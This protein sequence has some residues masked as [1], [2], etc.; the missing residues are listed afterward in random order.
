MRDLHVKDAS[1]DL[2]PLDTIVLL[3]IRACLSTVVCDDCGPDETTM[4]SQASRSVQRRSCLEGLIKNSGLADL[5]VS[6]RCSRF[7]ASS[8]AQNANHGHV[9]CAMET[10]CKACYRSLLPFPICCILERH[11]IHP[12]ALNA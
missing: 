3:I 7:T 10:L 8:I 1:A 4:L 5:V 9:P 2:R 6:Y 11:P 12:L